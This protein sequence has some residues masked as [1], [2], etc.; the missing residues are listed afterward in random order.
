MAK[1]KP[2]VV[3]GLTSNG[4]DFTTANLKWAV[5]DFE[6]EYK[7]VKDGNAGDFTQNMVRRVREVAGPEY[8]AMVFNTSDQPWVANLAGGPSPS[9]IPFQ[10]HAR[11]GH[12]NY[13]IWVFKNGSFENQ[14]DGGYG[15]WAFAGKFNSDSEVDKKINFHSDTPA[16][17][18]LC[19]T[20]KQPDY[21]A[22]PFSPAPRIGFY[23][24][25]PYTLIPN[26]D[27]YQNEA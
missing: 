9:D 7:N 5:K 8:N 10:D 22:Q 24:Q 19:T 15:N 26:V 14:G 20:S 25:D 27:L 23:C 1:D 21:D 2:S 4:D 16:P 18:T 11:Y 12:N 13:G 6:A 3:P 17:H